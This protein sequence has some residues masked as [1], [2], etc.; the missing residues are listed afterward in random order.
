MALYD[1]ATAAVKWVAVNALGM[2]M[3]WNACVGFGRVPRAQGCPVGVTAAIEVLGGRG[4][5][6]RRRL[7]VKQQSVPVNRLPLAATDGSCSSASGLSSA[8]VSSFRSFADS[9]SFAS[10]QAVDL[11]SDHMASGV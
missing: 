4:V 5:A 6:G 9:R 11:L 1:V 3:G 10:E 2:R 7:T 8:G